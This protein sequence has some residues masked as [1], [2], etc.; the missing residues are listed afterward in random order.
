MEDNNNQTENIKKTSMSS[1]SATN[2][3]I[4]QTP[5]ALSITQAASKQSDNKASKQKAK[6]DK[7]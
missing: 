1:Q 6:K 4:T 7:N 5:S 3:N 2:V